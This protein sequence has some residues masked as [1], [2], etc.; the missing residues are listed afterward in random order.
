MKILEIELSNIGPHKS[1]KTGRL[2]QSVSLNGP[3]GGGKSSVLKAIEACLVGKWSDLKNENAASFVRFNYLPEDHPMRPKSGFVRLKLEHDGKLIEIYRQEGYRTIHRIEVEGEEPVTGVNEVLKRIEKLFETPLDSVRDAVFVKQ[4][5]LAEMFFDTPAI[6]VDNFIKLFNCGYIPGRVDY[7]NGKITHLQK[8]FVDYGPALEE[9]E[10]QLGLSL[11]RSEEALEKLKTFGDADLV[12]RV[13]KLQR[14][15]SRIKELDVLN[16]ELNAMISS[17]GSLA[18]R[19]NA[20]E[21][22]LSKQK[23][24]NDQ[25]DTVEKEWN[26]LRG[27]FSAIEISV[28]EKQKLLERVDLEYQL[29]VHAERLKAL[30]GSD[31]STS[32]TNLDMLKERLRNFRLLSFELGKMGSILAAK[33]LIQTLEAEI[34]A[35]QKNI[36]RKVETL[37]SLSAVYYKSKDLLE[38]LENFIEFRKKIAG[39]KCSGDRTSCPVCSLTVDPEEAS[40]SE[41]I[42]KMEDE[43]K[44]LLEKRQEQLSEL[45]KLEVEIETLREDEKVKN[46]NIYT[47]RIKVEQYELGI[48]TLA[49]SVG[50]ELDVES[51]DFTKELNN[52]ADELSEKIKRIEAVQKSI[53]DTLTSISIIESSISKSSV[54]LPEDFEPSDSFKKKI[55]AEIETL[56]K[57]KSEIDSE[58]QKQLSEQITELKASL[59]KTKEFETTLKL[60]IQRVTDKESEL[61]IKEA[62]LVSMKDATGLLSVLAEE[63]KDLGFWESSLVSAEEHRNAKIEA[64]TTYNN[65]VLSVRNAENSVH[66]IKA[67]MKAQA[68]TQKIIAE[69]QELRTVF[70]REG[71]IDNYIQKQFEIVAK[72]ASITLRKFG[73][74]FVI[75]NDP[76]NPCSIR[77]LPLNRNL[78][79]YFQ[80]QVKLSGGQKVCVAIAILMAIHQILIPRIGLLIVDEPSHHLGEANLANLREFLISINS[81]LRS[82]NLQVIYSDHAKELKDIAESNVEVVAEGDQEI[83]EIPETIEEAAL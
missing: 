79:P 26:D 61:K 51:S 57:E 17:S 71:I 25:L 29:N 9:S 37:N 80:P 66:E 14:V 34:V 15:V 83:L 31:E 1:F 18:L 28:L 35:I 2:G 65:T 7:I 45:K 23:D 16:A 33:K 44:T 22:N 81:G 5:A 67:K 11:N 42:A 8:N 82:Q 30:K 39:S 43:V 24:L 73:A 54:N 10:K 41:A 36:E 3:N 38:Q 20:L 63:Q 21:N 49:G 77:F 58:K 68:K 40:D 72:M 70:S 47:T 55:S 52:S 27:R 76:D 50:V 69:L 4:G 53:A 75:E 12:E 78:P 62:E 46:N 64:Q 6:R 48:K 60:G 74:D 59:K 32:I 13:R 19:K 56:V